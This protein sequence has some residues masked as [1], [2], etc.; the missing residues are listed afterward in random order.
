M[1]LVL[2]AVVLLSGAVYAQ[3]PT[4]TLR[5]L[6]NGKTSDTTSTFSLWFKNTSTARVQYAMGQFVLDFNATWL[7]GTATLAI[8]S[9]DLPVNLHPRNPTISLTTNPGQLRFATSPVPGAGNGC[10][11][12]AG[13]S[14]LILTAQITCLNG[15]T[16]VPPNLVFRRENPKV[17]IIYYINNLLVAVTDS[18][19]FF[20]WALEPQISLISPIGGEVFTTKTDEYI[21]GMS[22]YISIIKIEYTPDDRTWFTICSVDAAD[23]VFSIDW[24]PPNT[25]STHCRIRVSDVDHPAVFA[26]SPNTFTIRAAIPPAVDLQLSIKDNAGGNQYLR[27]G[28]DPAAT[29]SIDVALGETEASKLNT[30]GVFDARFIGTHIAIPIGFGLY[31]DYRQ[32][33][34]SF[35]GNKTYELKYQPATGGTTITIQWELPDN[36][37]GVLQ[38]ILTGNMVNKKMK[39]NDSLIISD[40]T[41][42]NL[43]M[44]ITYGSVRSSIRMLK[45][46]N[47]VSVPVA[48]PDMSLSSVFPNSIS[49][50]FTYDKTYSSTTSLSNGIGYWLKFSDS[51]TSTIDGGGI[52]R[53]T[54]A[55]ANE[56]NLFGVYNTSVSVGAVTSTPSNII[57]SPFYEYDKGYK[58]ATTLIPG[59]GYWVRTSQAGLINLNPALEKVNAMAEVLPPKEWGRITVSDAAGRSTTLYTVVGEILTQ[60]PMRQFDLPPMPPAGTFD[61]RFGSQSSVEKLGAAAKDIW[62]QGARY[63]VH[64]SIDGAGLVLRDKAT[65]GKLFSATVNGKKSVLLSNENIDRLE[66]AAIAKPVAFGLL[67]NYPNPFNPTTIITYQVPS[68]A[69][70]TIKLYDILGNEVKTLVNEQKDTGE[71]TIELNAASLSSGVYFY[72]MKANSF[73]AIKKLM[74]LK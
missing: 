58:L 28:I 50:A 16:A 3:L 38:D 48:T 15:F 46:W 70:V 18:S 40:L 44:T 14:I 67:Q 63:P 10:W 35:S 41:I 39:G 30:V 42:S 25:P 13:D 62:I 66:V 32:E 37:T 56:W 8:V 24:T 68:N 57:T 23:G 49:Q 31:N 60:Q 2:F 17:S 47:L 51:T 12:K 73:T 27:F 74:L 33:K 36:I 20:D 4:S 29:D 22:R 11:I 65:G 5:V 19:T 34:S 72:S 52:T 43:K 21:E 6:L 7:K 54:I 26:V 1:L 9:S 45:N 61:V 59:K 53:K 64:I 71:Y 69:I 55:V